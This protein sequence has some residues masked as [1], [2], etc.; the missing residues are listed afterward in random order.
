M[1]AHRHQQPQVLTAKAGRWVVKVNR[2]ADEQVV[3]LGPLDS[4][5]V[6]PGS[7]RSMTLLDHAG[8]RAA[9]PGYGEMLVVNGGDGRTILEW[10]DDV[11][12]AARAAGTVLDPNGYRAP[13][14][15]LADAT[16]DD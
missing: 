15:V 8:G 9:E 16:E 2:G 1:L 3:E 4:L 6:P 14:A 11:V 10:A 7:W 13:V 12:A 5:S